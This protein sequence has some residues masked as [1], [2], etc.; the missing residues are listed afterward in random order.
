[1]GV[2]PA[3]PR[4]HDLHKSAFWIYGVTAMIMRE[5]MGTVL[6]HAAAVSW[7]DP[8]VRQEAVRAL[9]VLF[10]MSRQFLASGIYF[11]RVY[12]QPDSLDR[13]PRRN[14]PL[15]FLFGMGELL[16]ALAASTVLALPTPMFDYL[17]G[18][19]LLAAGL[20]AI[21]AA[22]LDYS[23]KSLLGK[24]AIFNAGIMV[25]CAGVRVVSNEFAAGV[26]LLAMGTVQMSLLIRDF[27]KS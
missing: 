18:L 4:I 7:H 9:V 12:L 23:T 3:S 2:E 27:N 24:A 13:F 26:V 14:Y 20:L 11:D 22:V 15:D 21:P 25:V 1:M 10:L 16:L 17:V 8:M 5:P 6:R 19:N